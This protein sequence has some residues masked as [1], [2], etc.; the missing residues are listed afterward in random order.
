MKSLEL[1]DVK[2]RE[3]RKDCKAKASVAVC[4]YGDK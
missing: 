3:L 4:T 2:N 1:N